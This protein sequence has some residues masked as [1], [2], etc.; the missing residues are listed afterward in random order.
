M[1][2]D[3]VDIRYPNNDMRIGNF[4]QQ[5]TGMIL[6]LICIFTGSGWINK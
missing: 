2:F 5:H 1:I 4:V 6:K 3:F